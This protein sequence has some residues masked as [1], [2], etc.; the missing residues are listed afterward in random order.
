MDMIDPKLIREDPDLIRRSQARRNAPVELVDRAVAADQNRRSTIAKFEST[1]ASQK[2]IGG[3]IAKA[4]D[5]ERKEL[6]A[7][8]KELAAEVK[9][10]QAQADEAEKEFHDVAMALGNIV[11]DDV[12]EGG[13]DDLYVIDEWGTPRDFEAEGF[14]AADHLEIGEKIGALDLSLIH[15]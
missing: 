9:S 1:R 13:E 11:I 15:I 14:E 6:L 8:T 12:P 2:K 10:L 7:K 4:S 5:E 3:Q